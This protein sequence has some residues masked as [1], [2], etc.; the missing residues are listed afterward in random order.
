[1][2]CLRRLGGIKKQQISQELRTFSRNSLQKSLIGKLTPGE[3]FQPH[4]TSKTR[5]LLKL[6]QPVELPVPIPERVQN[7]RL[8]MIPHLSFPFSSKKGNTQNLISDQS[9]GAEDAD[10]R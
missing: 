7:L 8:K 4:F 10:A 1:V 3:G 5:T 2:A 9:K 6:T